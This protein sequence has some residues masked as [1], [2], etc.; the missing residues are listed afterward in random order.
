MDRRPLSWF[1]RSWPTTTRSS[2]LNVANGI[3]WSRVPYLTARDTLGLCMLWGTVL[4]SLPVPTWLLK[5][6]L[7]DER[8]IGNRMWTMMRFKVFTSSL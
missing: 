3:H 6:N 2:W 7:V 4:Q 5:K 8:T 1:G